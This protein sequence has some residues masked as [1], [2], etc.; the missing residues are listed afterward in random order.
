[1]TVE[2]LI[3]RYVYQH[4]E[5]SLQGIGTIKLLDAIPEAEY[6]QKHRLVVIN[7][8]EFVHLKGAVT[9]PDFVKYYA[10]QR[11]KIASLAQNDIE[12][13]LNMAIQFLNI[14]NPFEIKGLGTLSKIN[15]GTL[16]M[17]PGFFVITKEDEGVAKFKERLT[18]VDEKSVT[19][20][21][22]EVEQKPNPLVKIL[23]GAIL[24]IVVIAGGWW[25]YSSFIKSKPASEETTAGNT[26][27]LLVPQANTAVDSPAVTSTNQV[28]PVA[29]SFTVVSWKAYFRKINGK[30]T[31]N[32]VYTSLKKKIATPVYMD[33]QD[34]VTFQYYVQLQSAM[35]DTA[36][37]RDSIRKFF[38]RPI[39]LEKMQ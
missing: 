38:Q 13:Y 22:N 8:L 31:A 20:F 3:T 16:L 14:G 6:L 9:T 2:Q 7:G 26:D 33:T 30:D 34:S 24:V 5:I 25:L 29:D 32:A 21:Y 1:M 17:T 10:T 11:G 19:N 23:L 28:A 27:T 12:S 15:D 39:R 37:K 35:K 36:Y 4:G 18:E